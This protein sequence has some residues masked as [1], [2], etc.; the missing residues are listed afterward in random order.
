MAHGRSFGYLFR[1]DGEESQ[2]LGGAGVDE[3]VAVALGTV[4]ALAG[5]EALLTVII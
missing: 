2:W 4:V 3:G 5:A 1:N